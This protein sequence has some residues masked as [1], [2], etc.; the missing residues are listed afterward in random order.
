MGLEGCD[1]EDDRIDMIEG[2]ITSGDFYKL[3]DLELIGKLNRK[4]NRKLNGTNAWLSTVLFIFD[5]SPQDF[6]NHFN[7]HFN[8]HFYLLIL[9]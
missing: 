6:L 1:R 9:N 3:N 5:V 7:F 4:L 2:A 8:F